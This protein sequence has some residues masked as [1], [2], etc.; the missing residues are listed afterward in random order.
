MSVYA[1][2]W[3]RTNF[4]KRGHCQSNL[5][6]EVEHMTDWYIKKIL[7]NLQYVYALSARVYVLTKSP[8]DWKVVQLSHLDFRCN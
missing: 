6:Q 8:S 5:G 4:D 1:C 3:C 7:Y 2:P